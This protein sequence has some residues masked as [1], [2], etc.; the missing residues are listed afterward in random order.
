[1][2]NLCLCWVLGSTRPTV[3]SSMEVDFLHLNIIQQS[4][5]PGHASTVNVAVAL[6]PCP[7]NEV[8]IT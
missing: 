7:I 5:E 3:L 6:V 4:S 2:V 1:M 8:K